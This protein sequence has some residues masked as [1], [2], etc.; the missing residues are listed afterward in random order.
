MMTLNHLL[1]RSFLH[2]IFHFLY[3]SLFKL[4]GVVHFLC[5][6]YMSSFVH[7]LC[8]GQA[9]YHVLDFDNACNFFSSLH[10]LSL[11]H[12]LIVLVVFISIVCSHYLCHIPCFCHVQRYLPCLNFLST[13]MFHV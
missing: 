11:L 2:C 12:M 5:D 7:F 10:L 9:F 4:C 13:I 6:N 1:P 3:Y 8:C